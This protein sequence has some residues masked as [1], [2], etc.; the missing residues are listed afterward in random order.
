MV[1]TKLSLLSHPDRLFIGGQWV[2]P[3]TGASFPITNPAS[4][5]TM[6]VIAEAREA[7]IDRAIAA[8]DMAFREGAWPRMAPAERLAVLRRWADAIEARTLDIAT[9]HTAQIG[10]PISFSRRVAGGAAASLRHM[11]QA[12][13]TYPFEA[14]RPAAGGIA[15]VI[16]EP[17]GVVAAIVPWNYPSLLAMNKM[18]PALAAGC[19]VIVKPSPEAPL[20][21][22]ILAECAEQA[23]FPDGV[24][25]LL[26]AGRDMGERL[27]SDPR[28]DKVSFTGST[29]A[30]KHIAARCM[31]RVARVT[32]ELGGKSA[33]ILLDDFPI[34]AAVPMLVGQS[35]LFNGQACMGLTRVLVSRPRQ[36]ELVTALAAA[37]R[38]LKT[39]DPFDEETR[40][41]PVAS[42][43]QAA[44]VAAYIEAGKEQGARLITG[45]T[46]QGCF[47]EPTL[48]ADVTNEMRIAREEIFG[49]VLVV[50][51]YD[52]LDQ[53]I[54]MANDSPYGLNGAVFTTD[55]TQAVAIARRIR[56]GTVAQNG[57]GPQAGQPFGG[58]KQSGIG[59]EGSA[60]ALDHYTEIKTI[61]L[62]QPA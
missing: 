25:S 60:E 48:F 52:S 21:C 32:L 11:I 12:A 39:G 22:L 5:A 61:Y 8:A 31:E 27:I 23:G 38:S 20:D 1:P 58:F 41:G 10:I 16:R 4:G 55:Q 62:S 45:G 44:R 34:A 46:V 14:E 35:T 7:D 13:E 47:I 56:S 3:S 29:A 26:T 9:A 30:G 50:L 19:T 36:E 59:R 18:A 53:A 42:P 15:R 33:A 40:I 57:M 17:V 2:E 24:L 43:V 6:T 51:P 37:Y 49:P 54:A 28:I